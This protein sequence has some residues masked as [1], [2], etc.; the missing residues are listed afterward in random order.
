MKPA[1]F[2][3]KKAKSLDEAVALLGAHER[4]PPARR[5]PEPDR[6]AQHAAVGADLADRHQRHS[7]PRRHR[8]ERWHGRDRRL[9]ATR[10]GRTLRPHRPTRAADRA[11]H[12]ASSP[13]PRSA[14]AAR[15]AARLLSPIRPPNCRP[16]CWRSTA[17]STPT[18]PKG[19]RTIKAQDYFKG[20]LRDRSRPAGHTDSASGCRRRPR[21]RASALPNWRA[22]M[23]TTPSSA[24]RPAPAP[25]ARALK[26]CG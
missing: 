16:A 8:A 26:T 6:H 21:T 25:T 15:S 1:P 11:R 19:K 10:P 18:G 23:A 22:G 9:G 3:Y 2:A 4:R 14:P 20:L 24:W 5:W 17:K 7:R 12:A 13:T